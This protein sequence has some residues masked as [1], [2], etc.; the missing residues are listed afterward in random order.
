MP[1][2][3]KN[4]KWGGIVMEYKIKN[5]SIN[6]EIIGE[7]KAIVMLHGYYVDHR[8]MSGCMEP[9][10]SEKEGYKRIYIDLPGMG[11]SESAEWIKSS[12]DM[13]DIVINFIEKIIPNENFLLAGQSY[14]G[15]LSRGVVHKMANRIEGVLLICPVIVSKY[16]N[17]SVEESVILVKDMEFL[18]KLTPEEAEDFNLVVQN[19]RTYERTKNEY[20]GFEIAN[21]AFLQSLQQNGYAFSFDVDKLSKK[22]DN[23]SLIMLGKQ[24]SAVGYKDA[25]SIL[26]NFPRAT[27]TVLDRAGHCLQLEQEKLFNILINDWLIRVSEL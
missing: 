9:I 7:G 27:F 1:L 20:C 10:F 3:K 14:G 11:K 15:Y 26:E 12:D 23:P 18:S 13:L 21:D 8:L 17:R 2:E 5:L 22:F 16:I 6:Y 24:D 4:S 19:E 25:W